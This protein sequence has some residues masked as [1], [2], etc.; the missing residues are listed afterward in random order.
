MLAIPPLPYRGEAGVGV[1]VA[2]AGAVP[3]LAD[4]V[5][6]P[7]A[8]N[9]LVFALIVVVGMTSGTARLVGGEPPG[10]ILAVVR[11]TVAT[12]DTGSVPTWKIGRRMTE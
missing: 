1:F 10:N 8:I 5:K 3:Q 12:S 11:M 6:N 9:F 4:R 2:G 7:W